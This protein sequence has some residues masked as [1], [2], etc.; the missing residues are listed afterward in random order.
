MTGTKVPRRTAK[1]AANV[2][3]SDK[4]MVERASMEAKAG[5][6]TMAGAIAAMAL[7]RSIFM[8][9]APAF[10]MV[11]A[12]PKN[13]SNPSDCTY[14][15]N[16]IGLHFVDIRMHT[17]RR[18]KRKMHAT[19]T[20]KQNGQRQHKNTKLFLNLTTVEGSGCGKHGKERKD[21]GEHF[22]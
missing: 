1:Y 16:E 20:Q 4:G 2:T 3:S 5:P 12:A 21:L 14:T 10:I 11:R 19:G 6:A 7:G 9:M 8:D 15:I 13:N 22:I 17:K 18:N